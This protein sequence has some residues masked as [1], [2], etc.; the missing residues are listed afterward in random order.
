M[1]S[2]RPN[3]EW[4]SRMADIEDE[5]ASQAAGG[6]M[7]CP[8][9]CDGCSRL[10]QLHECQFQTAACD[11]GPWESCSHGYCQQCAEERRDDE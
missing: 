7:G 10:V 1:T 5:C 2:E 9:P 4:I 11:C 3:R 8:V 6:E